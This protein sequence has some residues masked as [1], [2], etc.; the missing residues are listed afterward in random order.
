MDPKNLLNLTPPP[1]RPPPS[2]QAG[3]FTYQIRDNLHSHKT[4]SRTKLF[5][6]IPKPIFSQM[7]VQ[8]LNQMTIL[9]PETLGVI[10]T[11]KRKCLTEL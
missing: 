3:L 5:F 7:F 1:P 11:V 4:I 6:S 10:Q 9:R 2:P 8:N